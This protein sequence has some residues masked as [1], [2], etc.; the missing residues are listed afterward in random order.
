MF[1]S[2]MPRIQ[3]RFYLSN[4]L[5]LVRYIQHISR[6]ENIAGQATQRIFRSDA[7]LVR[8]EDV[9][10]GCRI[11]PCLTLQDLLDTDVLGLY[12]HLSNRIQFLEG[13]S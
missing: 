12:K 11:I 4:Q 1:F 10:M 9:P 5:F 2:L 7:V 13:T 8:T 3:N 6:C